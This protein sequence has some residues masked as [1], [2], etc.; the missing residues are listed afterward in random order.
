MQIQPNISIRTNPAIKVKSAGLIRSSG[1]ADRSRV[2]IKSMIL[3]VRP[4]SS[5]GS[6]PEFETKRPCLLYHSEKDFC[7]LDQGR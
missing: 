7:P 2:R 6:I 1:P 4:N 3:A 5:R